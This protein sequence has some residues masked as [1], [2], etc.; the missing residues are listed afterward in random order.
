MYYADFEY[1]IKNYQKVQN[2]IYSV[3]K[4][5]RVFDP[6]VHYSYKDR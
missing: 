3:Y 4:K 5:N 6:H 1:F 2:N